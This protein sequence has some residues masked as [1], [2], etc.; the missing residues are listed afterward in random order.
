MQRVLPRRTDA[1]GVTVSTR[2]EGWRIRASGE[3]RDLFG[4]NETYL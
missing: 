1:R 2:G 4:R 3:R